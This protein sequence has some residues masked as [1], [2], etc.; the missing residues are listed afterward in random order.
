MFTKHKFTKQKE[1]FMDISSLDMPVETSKMQATV[2]AQQNQ[3][4]QLRNMLNDE[5]VETARAVENIP[6]LAQSGNIGTKV[7]TTA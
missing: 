5:Q 1:T 4:V 7:N 6:K 2:L 3:A